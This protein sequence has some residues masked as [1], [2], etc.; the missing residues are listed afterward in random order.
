[1]VLRNFINENFKFINPHEEYFNRIRD[2]YFLCLPFD[3]SPFYCKEDFE[4]NDNR[5]IMTWPKFCSNI[6]F[7]AGIYTGGLFYCS[8]FCCV[9]KKITYGI[10][11]PIFTLPFLLTGVVTQSAVTAPFCL[12]TGLANALTLRKI[13]AI[14]FFSN[15]C[16]KATTL[17]FVQLQMQRYENNAGQEISVR[18]TLPNQINMGQQYM[19]ESDIVAQSGVIRANQNVPRRNDRSSQYVF[20]FNYETFKADLNKVPI[21]NDSR[22]LI[23]NFL[24]SPSS[25]IDDP[26]T[27][28]FYYESSPMAPT[29]SHQLGS[30]NRYNKIFLDFACV[31]FFKN[32]SDGQINNCNQEVLNSMKKDIESYISK[33]LDYS[34]SRSEETKLIFK[35]S[36]LFLAAC[37]NFGIKDP[38]DSDTNNEYS[39]F[40]FYWN[41]QNLS[42]S[43]PNQFNMAT[44]SDQNYNYSQYNQSED[45]SVVISSNPQQYH[46]SQYHLPRL[47]SSSITRSELTSSPE[48]LIISSINLQSLPANS[49][50]T[51]HA[52]HIQYA[53]QPNSRWV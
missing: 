17:S 13:S 41:R 9:A 34:E 19:I 33:N 4:C 11:V 20:N 5:L 28:T 49:P 26:V 12:L 27:G 23:F 24:S 47:I 2:Q 8:P 42:L 6:G 36:P 39:S 3:E 30:P 7:L 25:F 43:L 32:R 21:N 45:M 38:N 40:E 15:F 29:L 52:R 22:K 51:D 1:M 35:N 48:A 46:L 37:E 53:I 44:Q 14:D 18:N 10:T 31:A 50:S 16:L